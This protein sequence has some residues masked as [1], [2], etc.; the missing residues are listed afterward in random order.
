V[1]TFEA[2]LL[3]IIQGLT[4]FLPISSSGHLVLLQHFLGLQHLDQL[5]LFDLVC[6][7]GTLMAI[8]YFFRSQLKIILLYDSTKVKQVLFALLPLFLLVPLMK[9]I[10]AVFGQVHYLGYFFLINALI[11][12]LGI[13]FGKNIPEAERKQGYLGSLAIGFSQLIAI[14]PGISRSGT[15]I[16]SAR[17]LGW[18][19][20]HAVLFSFLLA[21]P[22][23]GGGA[24]YEFIKQLI[25]PE[26]STSLPLPTAAYI[27]GFVTS[28]LAG[29][30]SLKLLLNLAM[31]GQFMYF[32]WYSL[33]V[34]ILTLIFV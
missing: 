7:M 6:H 21:I 33:L 2:I 17:M 15:T 29:L 3:G 24:S 11:L 18:E 28:L 22:T 30:F 31:K 34:G 25:H 9:E 26:L 20:Y 8:L 12:Y 23:I 14:F 16:S 32:V 19:P 10:K 1:T 27:A 5:I 4:E 13:Y